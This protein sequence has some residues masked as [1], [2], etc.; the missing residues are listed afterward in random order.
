MQLQGWE[1]HCKKKR[2]QRDSTG[3]ILSPCL[4]IS[5]RSILGD[6]ILRGKKFGRV[7][8]EAM[9]IGERLDLDALMFRLLQLKCP[10]VGT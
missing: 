9:P 2:M 10:K 4:S 3:L 8:P 6:Q 5:L 7:P 1:H